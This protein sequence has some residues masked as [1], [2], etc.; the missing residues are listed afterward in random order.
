VEEREKGYVD[1][2]LGEEVLQ[3]AV[4]LLAAVVVATERLL[5]HDALVA[6]VARAGVY[7]RG[8]E[9]EYRR[10]SLQPR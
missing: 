3:E 1:G 5:H 9:K 4:Q 6:L 10:C 2:R 8:E 7:V